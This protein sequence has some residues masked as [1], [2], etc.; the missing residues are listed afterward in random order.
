M[1]S[2]A[3][4]P[5]GHYFASGYTDPWT[6]T[7]S[8]A[9]GSTSASGTFIVGASGYDTLAENYLHAVVLHAASGSRIGCGYLGTYSTISSAL[10]A[11]SYRAAS[12]DPLRTKL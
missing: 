1:C 12:Q 3:S 8:K 6:T 2:D 10:D 5:G 7:W 4:L 11:G 9:A